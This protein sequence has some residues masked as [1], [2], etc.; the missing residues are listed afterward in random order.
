[1]NSIVAKTYKQYASSGAL[2]NNALTFVLTTPRSML[3]SGRWQPTISAADQVCDALPDV[4]HPALDGGGIAL[5]TKN[6]ANDALTCEK[7]ARRYGKRTRFACNRRLTF[8]GRTLGR[9]KYPESAVAFSRWTQSTNLWT[10]TSLMALPGHIRQTISGRLSCIYIAVTFAAASIL[11]ISY[12]RENRRRNVAST[13][14]GIA[15]PSALRRLQ[16]Q[17]SAAQLLCEQT[18]TLP[19]GTFLPAA[20]IQY[21]HPP[22]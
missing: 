6:A 18:C 13:C 8:G 3:N 21:T 1:M 2:P 5:V 22:P 20:Q 9:R 11:I 12:L 17:L 19:S 10:R 4:R 15:E 16:L 14:G 7:A